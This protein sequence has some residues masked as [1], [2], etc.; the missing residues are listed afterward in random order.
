MQLKNVLIVLLVLSSAVAG[1][2]QLPPKTAPQTPAQITLDGMLRACDA[3]TTE[4][5]AARKYIATLEAEGA[6]KD[7]AL[8]AYKAQ[9]K[10]QQTALDEARA[11]LTVKAQLTDT[12][13]REIE[14]HKAQALELRDQLAKAKQD[15]RRWRKIGLITGGLVVLFVVAAGR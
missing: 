6:T 9:V 2:T 4:L 12:Q 14:T 15:A 13:A 1:Q 5:E 7:E 8:A 11:A 10:A 3:V